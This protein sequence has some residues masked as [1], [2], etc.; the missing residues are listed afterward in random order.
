MH[1]V[2]LTSLLTVS[3]FRV[4]AAC[5]TVSVAQRV[6]LAMSPAAM[7]MHPSGHYLLLAASN[8]Q[9]DVLHLQAGRLKGT[10]K[11]SANLSLTDFTGISDEW[12]ALSVDTQAT[13]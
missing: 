11:A 6:N 9:V 3:V 7:A 5:R 8:G 1:L 2:T 4:D 12:R 13:I 10:F